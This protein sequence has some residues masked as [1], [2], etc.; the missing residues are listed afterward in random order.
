MKA[1]TPLMKLEVDRRVR[2]GF[3]RPASPLTLDSWHYAAL[4]LTD[5]QRLY[6]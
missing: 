4:G 3:R 5:S 2:L 6:P 1:P